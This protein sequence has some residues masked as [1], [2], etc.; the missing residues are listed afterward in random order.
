MK[1][2]CWPRCC[3]SIDVKQVLC[4]ILLASVNWS[5]LLWSLETLSLSRRYYGGGL[6]AKEF[7]CINVARWLQSKVSPESLRLAVSLKW[8]ASWGASQDYRV[9][10]HLFKSVG[11]PTVDVLLYKPLLAKSVDL[12]TSLSVLVFLADLL[13]LRDFK[14]FEVL[15]VSSFCC[16]GF[17]Y[18]ALVPFWK[19]WVSEMVARCV[20]GGWTEMLC[21]IYD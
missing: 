12:K 5:W 21:F 13:G 18:A 9:S 16:D 2:F 4:L 7:L 19:I 1:N 20:T 15:Q 14:L 17:I 10:S 6:V 3:L 8:L 11:P